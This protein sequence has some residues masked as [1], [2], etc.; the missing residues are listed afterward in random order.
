MS[1][2]QKRSQIAIRSLLTLTIALAFRQSS[3][4]WLAVTLRL[5]PP[6]I[7]IYIYIYIRTPIK[8]FHHV[9]AFRNTTLMTYI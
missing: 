2:Q 7:Y 6:L 1:E 5:R 3:G 9:A 4:D 8:Q